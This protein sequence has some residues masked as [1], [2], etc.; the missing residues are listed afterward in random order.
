MFLKFDCGSY[1]Y[2]TQKLCLCPDARL[3]VLTPHLLSE[4]AISSP[5][6]MGL[7]QYFFK[8]IFAAKQI[9]FTGFLFVG[10]WRKIRLYNTN[11]KKCNLSMISKNYILHG[12]FTR[13]PP[14]MIDFYTS[15]I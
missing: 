1:Y 9:H 3:A 8:E 15:H 7:K 5:H 4:K 2:Q 13:Y 6:N 12:S 14:V 11:Y 10:E